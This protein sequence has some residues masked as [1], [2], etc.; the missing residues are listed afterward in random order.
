MDKIFVLSISNLYSIEKGNANLLLEGVTSIA[1]TS[2]GKIYLFGRDSE[3]VSID[4]N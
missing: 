2:D 1:M 4:L 3:H